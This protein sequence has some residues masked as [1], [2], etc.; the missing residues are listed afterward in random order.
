MRPSYRVGRYRTG[1]RS[2]TA[3]PQAVPFPPEDLRRLDA[4]LLERDARMVV[5]VHHRD[6]GAFG[7]GYRAIRVLHQGDLE[8]GGRTLY[9]ALTAFDALITDMSSVWLDYLLLDR[10]MIF[11]FPDVQAYRDGRG[12]NLEPYE[13]WVP[14]PFAR[15]VEEMISAM[16]DV[17]DGLDTMAGER[18]LARLRFHRFHD[19]RSSERLLD[20]LGL[21]AAG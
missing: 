7:D 17:V 12:L 14:G 5:K 11:A 2:E 3:D 13:D 21:L 16:G 9:P 20:G 4:W 1:L 18:R 8:A 15:T 6:A 10:P 19:D